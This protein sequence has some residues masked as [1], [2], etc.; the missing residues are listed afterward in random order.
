MPRDNKR[1]KTALGYMKQSA[2][3]NTDP[4]HR[5]L[6]WNSRGHHQSPTSQ[7]SYTNSSEALGFA[8]THLIPHNCS[9]SIRLRI[10]RF[11]PG[12]DT[13]TNLPFI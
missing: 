4:C 3:Y 2:V 11:W 5:Q 8:A 12:Q 10:G 13:S 7:I 9:S 1:A 6:V